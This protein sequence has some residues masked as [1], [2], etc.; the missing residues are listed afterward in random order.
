MPNSK[1]GGPRFQTIDP[2]CII[3]DREQGSARAAHLRHQERVSP[4]ADLHHPATSHPLRESLTCPRIIGM[5]P[6]VNDHLVVHLQI[7][8]RHRGLPAHAKAL[9]QHVHPPLTSLHGARQRARAMSLRRRAGTG[10]TEVG[11][12]P[13]AIP[14]PL[15][16]RPRR[17][18]RAL[19]L[20]PHPVDTSR[21]EPP[22]LAARPPPII[23]LI[24]LVA[25]E[26][27]VQA[28]L[29]A[30]LPHHHLHPPPS[31]RFPIPVVPRR[32]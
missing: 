14:R 26:E 21:L 15:H 31:T 9:L 16:K 28:G 24:K 27:D 18:P 32:K 29:E 2:G 13:T 7:H 4:S 25:A 12:I 1:S 22:L 11:G 30:E 23:H 20:H 19:L 10:L 17:L 3:T 5:S 6:L 8:I